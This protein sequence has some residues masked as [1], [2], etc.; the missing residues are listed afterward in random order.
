MRLRIVYA[1]IAADR[2]AKAFLDHRF[3]VSQEVIA[4]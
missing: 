4:V 2:S 1:S 3:A